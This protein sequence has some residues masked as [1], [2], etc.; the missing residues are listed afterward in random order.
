MWQ[1]QPKNRA[2]SFS[3]FMQLNLR[4]C[5]STIEEDPDWF[6]NLS[7]N[8]KTKEEYLSK[9]C[10]ARVR[11]YLAKAE[12]QLKATNLSAKSKTQ[13]DFE[14]HTSKI[15]NEFRR[16]LKENKFYGHYFDRKSESSDQICD[17]VGQFLCEG[18]FDEDVCFYNCKNE[19]PTPVHVINPYES[20][21]AR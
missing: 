3:L 5:Y 4:F 9:S 20:P 8:A 2:L 1:C 21:E 17:N 19:N 10:Q 6:Q 7:T 13:R 15:L 11:G 16:K 14:I 18:Q 12:S